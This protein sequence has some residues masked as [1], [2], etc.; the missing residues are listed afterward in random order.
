MSSIATSFKSALLVTA[1]AFFAGVPTAHAEPKPVPHVFLYEMGVPG[2]DEALRAG[3][4]LEDFTQKAKLE[5]W[6]VQ[7]EAMTS[8]RHIEVY[9]AKDA[10]IENMVVNRLKGCESFDATCRRYV[11]NLNR[12]KVDDVAQLD[13]YEGEVLLPAQTLRYKV[14]VDAKNH[15]K[16]EYVAVAGQKQLKQ[17]ATMSSDFN[18][19]LAPLRPQTIAGWESFCNEN[20]CVQLYELKVQ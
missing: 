4:A 3:T 20:G 7:T 16:E 8:T 14:T 5:G 10:S 15:Y 11:G 6:A 1:M 17:V 18:E 19:A 13:A 2:T 12:R 9:K